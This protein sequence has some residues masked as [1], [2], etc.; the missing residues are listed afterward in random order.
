MY[1]LVKSS[2]LNSIKK[3]TY[4]KHVN[5]EAGPFLLLFNV[6]HIRCELQCKEHNMKKADGFTF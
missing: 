5:E 6:Q 3:T 2:T 4:T 1:M